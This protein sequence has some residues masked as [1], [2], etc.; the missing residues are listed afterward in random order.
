MK[1]LIIHPGS[2]KTATSSFQADLRHNRTR[3][4]E[5]GI[6]VILPRDVRGSSYMG[7]YLDS[8][9][10]AVAPGFAAAADGFFRP[11]REAWG[12]VIF[13]EETLCH[14]FMPSRRFGSGG[15]DRAEEAARLIAQSGFD[16]YRVVLTIRPQFD[17]LTSTYT[18]FVHRHREARSF[19]EWF[20]DEVDPARMMWC[21]VIDAFADVFGRK[22]VH[23][24]PMGGSFA[25]YRARFLQALATGID[26]Q[27]HDEGEVFNPSPSQRAVSI[28]RMLNR[29][30][31]EAPKSEKINTLIVDQFPAKEYG[32]FR[33]DWDLPPK[34]ADAFARDFAEART[35]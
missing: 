18:H 12:S 31:R 4:E 22:S 6:G 3:L 23:V 20:T 8:Y 33:P 11:F 35:R 32:K 13:S 15:I 34:W 5:K 7:A 25:G 30:V 10:G 19:A 17:L 27:T 9:R 29:E 2:P 26:W 1:T 16:A 21:R 14:D 24:V 28:C